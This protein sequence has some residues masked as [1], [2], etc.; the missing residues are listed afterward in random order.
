MSILAI[1]DQQDILGLYKLMLEGIPLLTAT[2]VAEGRRILKNQTIHAIILDISMPG[3]N[4]LSFLHE[5]QEQDNQIPII[6]VSGSWCAEA[7]ALEAGAK[8]FL[9][10]PHAFKSIRS[11]VE[12]HC[13]DSSDCSVNAE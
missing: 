3:E 4:G 9:M 13:M 7:T 2:S 10:K 1:D 12:E 6:V 8:H 11:I 5:M